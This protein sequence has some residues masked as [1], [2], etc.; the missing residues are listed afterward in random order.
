MYMSHINIKMNTCLH[1]CLQDLCLQDSIDG[2]ENS[3]DDDDNE[4]FL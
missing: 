1:T 3:I 4:G 2:A